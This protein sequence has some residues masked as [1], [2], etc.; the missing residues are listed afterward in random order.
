MRRCLRH[1]GTR[2]H[3]CALGDRG[4][5]LQRQPAAGDRR[6]GAGSPLGHGFAAG[7]R[8]RA[9]GDHAQQTRLYFEVGGGGLR[10]RDR[11]AA[12]SAHRADRAGVLRRSLR[13]LPG[14]GRPAR[15]AAR[16]PARPRSRRR[17]G[18]GRESCGADSRCRSTRRHRRHRRLL[19]ARR[20]TAPRLRREDGR[21]RLPERPR[22]GMPAARSPELPLALPLGRA[23]RGGPGRRR[24]RA[25]RLP[26]QL[27]PAAGHARRRADH[28]CRLRRLSQA[29]SGRGR[30][31]RRYRHVASGAGRER[32]RRR[33]RPAV[34]LAGEAG[35]KGEEL[36]RAGPGSGRVGRCAHPPGPP[37]RRA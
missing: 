16:G 35:G 29:P 11:L 4:G 17:P 23:W 20:G 3:Q 22:Q 36:P 13:H 37:H 5:P 1:R 30:P 24:G 10:A 19:G 6:P 9:G 25:A 26:P 18:R 31:L 12:D 2:R 33:R 28:L 7:D 34:G 14:G 27:W 21:A 32:R 8:P 15:A